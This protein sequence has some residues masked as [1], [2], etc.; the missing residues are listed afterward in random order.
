MATRKPTRLSV[1]VDTAGPG[2]CRS[3]HAPITWY[4]LISGRRHPVNAGAVILQTQHDDA[5]QLVGTIDSSDS[6]FA[7]CPDAQKWSRR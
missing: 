3:C 1:L 4:E 7:T 2:T 5:G 6:H